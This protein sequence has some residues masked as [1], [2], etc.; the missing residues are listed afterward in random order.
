MFLLEYE[1]TGKLIR[2]LE[3]KTRIAENQLQ[4]AKD[5]HSRT[6]DEYERLEKALEELNQRMDALREESRDRAIRKQQLSGE[7]NVLHEQ[8]LAG[9]QNDSHYR[10]RLQA[11]QEDTEKKSADR[12]ELEEQRADLQAKLREKSGKSFS[13]EQEKL[14]RSRAHRRMYPGSRRWKERDHR[15]PQLPC[16]HQR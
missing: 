5:A 13:D 7:I 2:E 14:D 15:N 4:E 1:H 11:I 8:I 12:E 9:E 16:Q 10:S 6:K 3:E